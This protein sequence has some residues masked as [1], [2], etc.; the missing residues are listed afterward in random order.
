[1]DAAGRLAQP[2]RTPAACGSV[3]KH[4]V[5][6]GGSVHWVDIFRISSTCVSPRRRK[7]ARV[8]ESAGWRNPS[9]WINSL[10]TGGIVLLTILVRLVNLDQPIVENYVGRQVP[11]AMVARNLERGS[12]FLRPSLDTAPFPNYFLVEPPIYQW[13][14]VRL[15]IL[16]G[17]PL[18]ACGRIVSAVATGLGAWGLFGLIRRREGEAAAFAAVLAFGFFPILL[19]Y[20]RAFQPDALM[21]GA[22][23]GGV[24]CWDRIAPQRAWTWR[25]LG[26]FLLAIGFSAKIT[27]AVVLV[28]IG[29]SGP[30]ARRFTDILIATSALVPVLLWYGWANHVVNTEGGSLASAENRAIWFGIFGLSSLARWETLVQVCQFLVVRA[31]TPVGLILACCG[32]CLRPESGARPDIWKLWAV[33]VLAMM[34]ALSEKLH[35]EYYWLILAPVI[36][37]GLGRGWVALWSRKPGLA[38]MAACA[39]VATDLLFARSTWQTPPE[40]SDIEMVSVLVR[41]VVPPGTLLVAPEPLLFEADR[42]GCRLEFTARAARRAASE[43]GVQGTELIAGPLDLIEFYRS[44]GARCFADVAPV[45]GDARREALH[46]AIR[47]RYKVLIDDETGIV[48]ELEPAEIPRHVHRGASRHDS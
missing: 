5:Y 45:P 47:R 1:V 46:D 13:S 23:L 16:T 8:I 31:F 48:A 7:G 4:L 27:S 32:L 9:R 44:R 14:V 35:H 42:R 2:A 18:E 3:A 24:N 21:L 10:A 41:E 30:R 29:L 25:G 40:W 39:L 20:G 38:V 34:A 26:W 36:A 11:T 43:W 15:R 12:G 6:N 19:R 33:C 37:A 28:P 17:W 22:V